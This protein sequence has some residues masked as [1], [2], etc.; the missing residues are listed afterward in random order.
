MI[1]TKGQQKD[2]DCIKWFYPKAENTSEEEI[3]NFFDVSERG[4]IPIK[5][6]LLV[7]GKRWRGITIHEMWEQGILEGSVP[8]FVLLGGYEGKRKWYNPM[9]YIKCKYYHIPIPSFIVD[10]I[11]KEIFKGKDA[12]VIERCY[13]DIIKE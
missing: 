13:Q 4:A 3:E 12:D 6:N 11:K 8:Y 7:E 9:R 2:I 5:N 1:L 10:F